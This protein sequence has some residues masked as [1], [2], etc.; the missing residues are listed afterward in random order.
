MEVVKSQKGD[1]GPACLWLLPHMGHLTGF[2][3]DKKEHQGP[4]SP[5]RELFSNQTRKSRVE[6]T[7]AQRGDLPQ[8]QALAQE[9]QELNLALF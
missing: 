3:G 7:K 6:H 1:G 9:P 5:L 2:R 8:S 4:G